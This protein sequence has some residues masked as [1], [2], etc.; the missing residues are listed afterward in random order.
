MNEMLFLRRAIVE[1]AVVLYWLGV[2]VQARRIRRRIGRSPNLRPR[3]PRGPPPRDS[4]VNAKAS[5]SEPGGPGPAGAARA[6][7]VG[8][9]PA[10]D[11]WLIPPDTAP[12]RVADTRRQPMR[13]SALR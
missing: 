12:Q 13:L 4:G 8:R 2:I 6:D 1:T 3:G 7:G 11:V 10:V 5:G 9:T